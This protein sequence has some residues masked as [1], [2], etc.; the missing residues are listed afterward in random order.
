MPR[1][2]EPA[3]Y[4]RGYTAEQNAFMILLHA[5]LSLCALHSVL[6]DLCVKKSDIRISA[7]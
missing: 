3:P 4:R 7:H 5:V 1:P 6:R 2:R